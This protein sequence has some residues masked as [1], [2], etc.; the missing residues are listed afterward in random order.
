VALLR[1]E[2]A[3]RDNPMLDE[4]R[5][6]VAGMTLRVDTRNDVF[7]PWA[8]WYL[9]AEAE[10]GTG[11]VEAG[12]PTS[13][14]VRALRP[15]PTR[16]VRGFLDLRRYNRLGPNASLNLR[17]VIGGWL[18][19][20]AL[21][22]EKRLSIDGPGTVPGFDFRSIGGT[23]VGTCAQSIAPAGGPAQCERIALAQLEYRTDVRFSVSRGSGAT[24]RTRFRADGTWVFFADAGR[25]WLVN[26]PG[27]PLNVGRHELP[28]LSTYRTDLGGGVD[29]DAF[30]VYVAKA[31]SVPQEPMN[32]F[33]RIRHR[34]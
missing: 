7:N 8:G 19:G 1:N 21:P 29:F 6:H 23:D 2:L 12:G 5:F 22:L 28:P 13:P 14:G 31:L 11:T 15:G 34:F 27:S 17:G 16:Y 30:G 3:W 32:V 25:G 26:A 9:R 20:D 18:S 10:R 33:L 24:R 4:G